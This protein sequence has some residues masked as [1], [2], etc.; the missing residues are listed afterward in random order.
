MENPKTKP[1]TNRVTFRIDFHESDGKSIFAMCDKY[2]VDPREFIKLGTMR[3][4]GN[5]LSCRET[6][7]GNAARDLMKPQSD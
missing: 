5:I 7:P 3:Y 6:P 2:G 4:V 1:T